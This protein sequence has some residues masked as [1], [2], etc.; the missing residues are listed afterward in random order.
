MTKTVTV[1]DDEGVRWAVAEE[2]VEGWVGN[3][4]Y[5]LI[6]PGAKKVKV[7]DPNFVHETRDFKGEN[8]HQENV[9]EKTLVQ[10]ADGE[11]EE[12]VMKTN[13]LWEE[14]ESS[15]AAS[16]RMSIPAAVLICTIVFAVLFLIAAYV[17]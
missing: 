3:M 1:T 9:W 16:D 8:P 5:A 7:L 17:L 15:K 6:K 11:H 2:D 14:W 10:D 4:E 12:L 13:P